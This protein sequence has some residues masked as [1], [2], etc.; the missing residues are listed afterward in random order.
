MITETLISIY[1]RDL[2]KLKNEIEHY[3]SDEQFWLISGG[4]ANSGGNLALHLVGNLRHFIGAVLGGSG[5]VRD[6]DAE[7]ASKNV[8]R[9]E[10]IAAVEETTEVATAAIAKLTVDD[11]AATYPVDVFGHEMTTEYFLIH[12][13]THFNY[14]LGQINYHRRLLGS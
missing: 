1:Q 4:I 13:A 6:R 12:L 7:F 11:L 3:A 2:D 5:Y 10:L 14:H 9:D 8:S